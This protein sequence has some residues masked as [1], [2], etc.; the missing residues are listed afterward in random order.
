MT[1]NHFSHRQSESCGSFYFQT[2]QVGGNPNFPFGGPFSKPNRVP[3]WFQV[4]QLGALLQPLFLGE[5]SPL[6]RQNREKKWVPTYSNLSTGGKRRN[7]PK[8]SRLCLLL[9]LP[10]FVGVL[11]SEEE[12]EATP[13]PAYGTAEHN[14]RL[15]IEDPPRNA[16][17]WFQTDQPWTQKVGPSSDG[18]ALDPE[19]RT[20]DQL[21]TQLRWK[22]VGP[23]SDGL[24]PR[25]STDGPALDPESRT[26]RRWT[27]LGPRKS[28]PAQMDPV[29]AEYM[30][31]PS[32]QPSFM[33]TRSAC[34]WGFL[35]STAPNKSTH[36]AKSWAPLFEWDCFV[37]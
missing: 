26:Q 5:G 9:F 6:N 23:S 29:A 21:W 22:K 4:S 37:F 16:W 20:Q 2:F 11:S 15:E 19:S 3:F 31:T 24:G 1:Q 33:G 28:D 27:S 8:T 35:H 25:P 18:P 10:L 17:S 36:L 7:H 32:H 30:A 13:A 14:R 34:F 12:E